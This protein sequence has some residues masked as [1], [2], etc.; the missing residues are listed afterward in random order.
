SGP[1][2][3]A[4]F[5]NGAAWAIGAAQRRPDLIGA[6]AAFSAGVAPRRI[7]GAARSAGVRH[8]LAAGTLEPGFRRSTRE[9]AERLGRAG[10]PCRHEEWTGGHD[11]VWWEQQ[12]PVALGWL[13]A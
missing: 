4:G 11:Q 13:L 9:W 8:Y 5:S 1:W 10:L 2:V 6:V 7:S 3:A 12:L